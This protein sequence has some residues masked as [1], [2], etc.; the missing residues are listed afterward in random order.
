VTAQS[1]VDVRPAYIKGFRRDFSVW[2]AVGY[3]DEDLAPQLEYLNQMLGAA[4]LYGE[5]YYQETLDNTYIGNQALR[6]FPDLL[7][8]DK[9]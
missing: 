1:A 2:D 4:K 8:I 3:N 5:T 6:E 9:A 7:R